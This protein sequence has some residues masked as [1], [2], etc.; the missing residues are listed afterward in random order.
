MFANSG[1]VFGAAQSPWHAPMPPQDRTLRMH[2]V[3][4]A[5]YFIASGIWRHRWLRPA[6]SPPGNCTPIC[7][8]T[9]KEAVMPFSRCGVRET[10]PPKDRIAS[11]SPLGKS[12]CCRRYFRNVTRLTT[13]AAEICCS[14]V[15]EVRCSE[16]LVEIGKLKAARRPFSCDI[17][18]R[19]CFRTCSRISS[20]VL[21][22]RCEML[23]PCAAA[24]GER[25]FA[26]MRRRSSMPH[27]QICCR[28][29]RHRGC[30]W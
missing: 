27:A 23:M 7:S 22:K 14:A 3:S 8:L 12:S 19:K 5:V 4:S 26:S 29:V 21:T 25:C 11:L 18:F 10:P 30:V 1:R 17:P 15:D 24:R 20:E 16:A 9:F 6:L 28:I 13:S 2:S